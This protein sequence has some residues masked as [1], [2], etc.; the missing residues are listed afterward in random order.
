[1]KDNATDSP[2]TLIPGKRRK[3][4]PHLRDQSERV[5]INIWKG[6]LFFWA[7]FLSTIKGIWL[8]ERFENRKD[9]WVIKAERGSPKVVLK[10]FCC[11]GA[12]WAPSKQEKSKRWVFA[13]FDEIAVRTF[14]NR[15]TWSTCAS[16]FWWFLKAQSP[17]RWSDCCTL[18]LKCKNEYFHQLIIIENFH[19]DD[20]RFL[21]SLRIVVSSTYDN[22]FMSC[23]ESQKRSSRS[24]KWW[25]YDNCG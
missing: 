22:F 12:F 20:V 16:T 23:T 7:L 10:W 15:H 5:K 18:N 13:C 6:R 9:L 4:P 21:S 24:Q 2:R 3:P 1:M 19:A 25:L 17:V 8:F 14:A 11:V